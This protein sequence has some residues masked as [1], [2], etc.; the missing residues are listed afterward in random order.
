MKQVDKER[1][2]ESSI[3][4]KSYVIPIKIF[5]LQTLISKR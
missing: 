2:R 1:F 4:S 5:F 3:N